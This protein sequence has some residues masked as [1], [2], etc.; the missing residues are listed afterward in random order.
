[1]IHETVRIAVIAATAVIAVAGAQGAAAGAAAPSAVLVDADFGKSPGNWRRVPKHERI[2]GALPAGW[3]DDSSWARVWVNYRQVGKGGRRFLRATVARLDEGR[4]QF[5][6]II[7]DFGTPT[8]FRLTLTARSLTGSAAEIGIRMQGPPYEFLWSRTLAVPKR[9]RD[10]AFDFRLKQNPQTVGLWVNLS[11]VGSIDLAKVRLVR[12]TREGL[13]AEL[14]A[15]HP[16]GGPANLLRV[17]RM[18]LG[19]QSGW[20]LGRDNSDGDDVRIA[21][22]PNVVG[23]S[24]APS[25]SICSAERIVLHTA[26][27]DVPRAFEPHVASLYA[28]GTGKLHLSVVGGRRL[29]GKGSAELSGDRWQRLTVRFMPELMRRFYGLRLGGE[30]Q[31]WIDAL[32]VER[33]KEAGSYRS[34]LDCEV[35]LA[36]DSPIRVQFDDEKA[37]VRWAV[38]GKA[39]GAVLKG[40]VVT[41]YGRA[42]AL[43]D[44]KLSD[45]FLARGEWRYDRFPDTPYGVFRVEAWVEDAKGRPK[46]PPNEL[47]VYR[48]HRPRYWMKDAPDS[49]F[50][51]HTNSTTRHILMAKA[52]GINWTRLH[53]AGT[54]YIG[55]YHLE[56]EKGT[57]QFR[58]KELK[59]YRKYGMKVLGAFSTAPR[60]ASYFADQKPHSGYFDRFYQ[61]KRMEDFARYVRTV[62]E[63]YRGVI[64]DWDIWNEPWIHAWWGVDYDE[65]KKGRSGYLTSRSAPADF[66]A[67]MATAYRTAKAVNPKATILGVNS[68]S[69]R[70]GGANSFGGYEWT[71]G[72]VAAGGLKHCDVIC[73]HHY[74]AAFLG[75]PGDAC[76][77]GFANATGP[78]VEKLG[79]LPKDVWMTEGSPTPRG[80]G[81]GFYRYTVPQATEEDVFASADRLSRYVVSVLAQGARRVFLYSMHSHGYFGGGGWRVLVTP[82]G[83]LHPSAAAHSA[84]AWLLEDTRFVKRLTVCKG[85]TAYLFEGAGRA[86][87]VL[88]PMP[89]HADFTPPRGRGV[90]VLDL[91]GNPVPKGRPLGSRLVYLSA[92]GK[93]EKVA[94][95]LGAAK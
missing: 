68:T 5:H 87:A 55:W 47:V 46:S 24:G 92:P 95:L 69:S 20:S 64:D 77:H 35:A 62:A 84:M 53:D 16:A 1:M 26:P 75:Y 4:A 27:F 34:R 70:T 94:K 80:L 72:V 48:L 38:T 12:M 66:A 86:V 89:A 44:I 21:A 58:D 37:L 59:R 91:F 31:I 11:G 3:S 63:R 82:E 60:W 14:K 10:Y 90:E 50:G 2:G 15:R 25:L 23:P 51:T 73:Y 19:M 45:R 40:R 57:W 76:E 52:V 83:Y 78:I 7:P 6:Y 65:S 93:A 41:P 33:G 54:P 56:P 71:K 30:G 36:C 74:T 88:S 61:P 67:M 17:S 42:A 85:V 79:R 13:I 9:W 22:D 39:S 43:E 49:P 28:R 18:P 29:G 32:Q 8:Y 81:D